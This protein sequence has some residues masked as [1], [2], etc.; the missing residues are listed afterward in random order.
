ML[1]G[2]GLHWEALGCTG[3]HWV[4]LGYTGLYWGAIEGNGLHWAVL[5]YTGLYWVALG[6]TGL[7]WVILGDT[8]L[9][10]AALGAVE[11]GRLNFGVKSP[12]FGPRLAL[13]GNEAEPFWGRILGFWGRGPQRLGEKNKP[14]F[15]AKSPLLGGF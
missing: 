2:T 15:G 6:C 12:P 7:Y 14:H 5:G 3:G 11:K 13:G 8:G 10:W 4:I 1:E 9:Y